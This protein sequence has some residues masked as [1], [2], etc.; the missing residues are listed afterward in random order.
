VVQFLGSTSD[1]ALGF[2]PVLPTNPAWTTTAGGV[3][4]GL[5]ASSWTDGAG[6]TY[7]NAEHFVAPSNA[8]NVTITAT[9]AGHTLKEKFKVFEPSGVDTNHTY[10]VYDYTNA[11]YLLWGQGHSGAGM[12]IRVYVAPTDV[13][14]YRLQGIEVGENATNITGY[15]T[16]YMSL[17]DYSSN[18]SHIGQGANNPF[19]INP[20][21]SWQHDANYDWDHCEW[22]NYDPPPAWSAGGFTWNIPGAWSIG[23][24]IWHTNMS[25]WSQVFT[26]QSDG[27]MKIQKF[28]FTV[29]R[30]TNAP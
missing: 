2:T 26:L 20:D 3:T 6:N 7:Y 11:P 28:G 18:L 22:G 25:S 8:A 21:N 17:P 24:S 19:Q 29:T 10:K 1:V 15:Y 23:G 27:T 16:N 13:S 14:F 9:V 30:G 4:T 12:Y 5:P